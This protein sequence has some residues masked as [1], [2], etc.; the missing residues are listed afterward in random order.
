M[1]HNITRNEEAVS[2][3][4]S[5]ESLDSVEENWPTSP[6]DIE[7]S[8]EPEPRFFD[9]DSID[10]YASMDRGAQTIEIYT[11]FCGELSS[12]EASRGT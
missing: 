12:T 5:Y 9:A 1:K 3:A 4:D 2:A 8:S 7:L 6:D 11:R 10:A